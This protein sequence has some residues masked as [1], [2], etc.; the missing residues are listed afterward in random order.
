MP[1]AV[2]KTHT[3]S[4]EE[5]NNS[6]KSLL[7]LEDERVDD[8]WKVEKIATRRRISLAPSQHSAAMSNG[9]G[10]GGGGA[11]A[12]SEQAAARSVVRNHRASVLAKANTASFTK[13]GQTAA[14]GGAAS[15]AST[16]K[17]A[18]SPATV[19]EGN[20]EEE[21]DGEEGRQQPQQRP[22]SASN[23]VELAGADRGSETGVFSNPML[24]ANPMAGRLEVVQEDK[25]I[26]LLQGQKKKKSSMGLLFGNMRT[27]VNSDDVKRSSQS[28]RSRK[29]SNAGTDV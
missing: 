24:A 6:T 26:E 4:C 12:L 3:H 19:A 16:V 8:S 13:D 1:Q 20:E 17:F 27:R 28:G 25:R 11:A 18:S 29:S 21:E 10:G 15:S 14:A 7:S 2:N 23:A 22:T 5:V 9:G